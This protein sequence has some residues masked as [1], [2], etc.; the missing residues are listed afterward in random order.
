ME[1]SITLSSL[2]TEMMPTAD[3]TFVGDEDI[4]FVSVNLKM[5]HD[6]QIIISLHPALLKEFYETLDT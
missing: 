2:I 1:H 4:N 5:V 3:V 6:N